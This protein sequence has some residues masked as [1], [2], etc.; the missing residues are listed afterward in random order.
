MRVVAKK[1]LR[2]FWEANWD[3]QGSLSAWLHE[4]EK[5]TWTSPAEVKA[6]Y[7][8]SSIISDNRVVFNIHGNKYRLV[9]KIHYNRGIIYIRFIGTHEEYDRIDAEAI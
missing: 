7:Q 3:A 9:V 8:N 4:A 6:Q 5:A 1:P 2:E